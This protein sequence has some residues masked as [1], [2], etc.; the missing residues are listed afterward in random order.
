MT[1]QEQVTKVVKGKELTGTYV[2][3]NTIHIKGLGTV[4]RSGELDLKN[5][6]KDAMGLPSFWR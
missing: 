1:E 3:E 6:I 5:F 2:N 4:K